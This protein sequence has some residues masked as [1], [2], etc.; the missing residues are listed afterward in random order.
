M[1][2][3]VQ[4][5]QRFAG[6]TDTKGHLHCVKHMQICVCNKPCVFLSF[7]IEKK[8][9]INSAD[10]LLSNY[11]SANH[12][13][14]VL[15]T[16]LFVFEFM[17]LFGYV[18]DLWV[19]K[20]VKDIKAQWLCSPRPPRIFACSHAS[21]CKMICKLDQYIKEN[22]LR[23]VVGYRPQKSTR[24]FLPWFRKTIKETQVHPIS[25]QLKCLPKGV[26][27][28]KTIPVSGHNWLEAILVTFAGRRNK[29]L[30]FQLL[31]KSL[32]IS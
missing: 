13:M 9:T 17:R 24:L 4:T 6:V 16:I 28:L 27:Q 25:R 32:N 3:T 30:A 8:M 19:V 31:S 18:G 12:K 5:T 15:N 1:D 22:Y 21:I 14:R 7:P 26:S 29:C 11:I 10:L 2:S 20:W 23:L